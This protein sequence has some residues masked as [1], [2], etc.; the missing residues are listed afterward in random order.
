[1][2]TKVSH[3]KVSKTLFLRLCS[4]AFLAGTAQLWIAPSAYATC[5]YEGQTYETG[6]TVGPYVCM[7]GGDWKQQ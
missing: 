4:S 6:E 2:S 1:M 5:E 7:P 3:L